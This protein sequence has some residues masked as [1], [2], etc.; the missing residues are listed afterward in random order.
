MVKRRKKED[1]SR[2]RS[3]QR[4]RWFSIKD[5]QEQREAEKENI[6]LLPEAE[7][8]EKLS[9]K[10][11][12]SRKIRYHRKAAISTLLITAVCLFAGAWLTDYLHNSVFVAKDSIPLTSKKSDKLQMTFV[13]D[14]MMD[15][16][17]YRKGQHGGYNQFFSRSK[18]L[19]K[20]SD[21]T[22]GNLESVVLNDPKK[23]RKNPHT[24]IHLKMNT[25]GLNAIN[26]AGF[27]TMGLANNHIGDFGRKGMDNTL[28]AF[29]ERNMDYAGL[30]RNASNGLSYQIYNIDGIKVSFVA[31]TD[32][33]PK[34][35]SFRSD[36][37]GALTT[38]NND[39]LNLVQEAS[40]QSD[41]TVVYSHWGHENSFNVTD[42][43]KELG[44]KLTDAGAD[45]V[46]GMH[47][48]VLQPIEKY[49]NGLILYGMG[50]FVF[51]QEQSRGKDSVI[52][53]MR[54]N[55]DG[56]MELELVPMRIK[57]GV[58]A[59]TKNPFFKRRIYHQLDKNLDKSNYEK[60]SNSLLIKNFGYQYKLK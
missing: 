13:G 48:H 53:N 27:T 59:V 29:N 12:V 55:K 25:D 11:K 15:R 2:R 37:S 24:N 45:V 5:E 21:L 18:N 30:G 41:Y 1:I 22:I 40:A 10:E 49:K 23:Y 57:D 14:I 33:K 47:G 39:Y 44:H 6:K 51:E 38:R 17:N 54:M 3:Q 60:L 16:G 7:V 4:T 34:N 8:G 42:R 26:N 52:A 43:Q 36:M 35:T 56:K 46:V 19:W 50:N 32:V 9:F 20:D 58:P 31:V 28:E